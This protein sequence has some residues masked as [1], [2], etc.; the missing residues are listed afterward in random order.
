QTQECYKSSG[1]GSNV[2]IVV[3]IIV[4]ISVAVGAS[5]VAIDGGEDDGV[6]SC[7]MC[8]FVFLR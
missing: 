5:A 2:R 6:Y 1:F 8:Q 3:G 4:R 7:D